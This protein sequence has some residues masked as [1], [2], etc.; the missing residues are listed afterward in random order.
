MLQVLNDLALSA[1]IAIKTHK[2][3]SIASVVVAAA[4]LIPA[5]RHAI[6]NTAYDAYWGIAYHNN[7]GAG[8][9]ESFSVIAKDASGIKLSEKVMDLLPPGTVIEG[10]DCMVARHTH[11]KFGGGPDWRTTIHS[12]IKYSINT[13]KTGETTFALGTGSID[14]NHIFTST[15]TVNKDG[16]LSYKVHPGNQS[17]YHDL[18]QD[19]YAIK[20][21]HKIKLMA[22]SA[23]PITLGLMMIAE[24]Q[25][26]NQ[27]NPRSTARKLNGKFKLVGE[28]TGNKFLA[29]RNI[30]FQE[31]GSRLSSYF[32]RYGS[33]LSGP[34]QYDEKTGLLTLPAVTKVM[35]HQPA[36]T[37][38]PKRHLHKA[39]P[40]PMHQ[41]QRQRQLHPHKTHG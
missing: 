33:Q 7:A 12:G 39:A 36:P 21:G 15:T 20:D 9:S 6:E 25:V 37:L 23:D 30:P 1:L 24:D 16:V 5:S 17:G 29:V 8:V 32:Y 41:N 35:S 3:P 14:E 4:A 28:D 22:S 27:Y 2:A 34:V 18:R 11:G 31:N 13:P 10:V 38:V 26:C 19:M 40:R